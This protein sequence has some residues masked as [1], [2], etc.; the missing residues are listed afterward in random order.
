MKK[1]F[2]ALSVVALTQGIYWLGVFLGKKWG[3]ALG[4]RDAYQEATNVLKRMHD[5]L[6]DYNNTIIAKEE[7]SNKPEELLN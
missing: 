2:T 1:G 4:Q 5:E 6:E 7:I 3:Y